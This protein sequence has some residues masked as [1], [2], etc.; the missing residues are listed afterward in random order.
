MR[1]AEWR[2]L[3]MRNTTEQILAERHSRVGGVLLALS[4]VFSDWSGWH[5][6]SAKEIVG[7]DFIGV[8]GRV[9]LWSVTSLFVFHSCFLAS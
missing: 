3:G 5:T 7:L 6:K 8:F 4:M 2:E 9:T 1:F